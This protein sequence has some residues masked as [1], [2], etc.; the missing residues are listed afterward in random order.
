MLSTV[1]SPNLTDHLHQG[2]HTRWACNISCESFEIVLRAIDAFGSEYLK[3]RNSGFEFPPV[4]HSHGNVRLIRALEE[5][6]IFRGSLKARNYLELKIPCSQMNVLS[7]VDG[8][9]FNDT[10]K[11]HLE[12]NAA[13][14][15]WIAHISSFQLYL[16]LWYI[17]EFACRVRLADNEASVSN[18]FLISGVSAARE[19]AMNDAL[20]VIVAVF[21]GGSQ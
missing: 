5:L 10:Y 1:I 15:S 14:V 8:S 11:R 2:K 16:L 13:A 3:T 18:Q 21:H 6:A 20:S 9:V 19:T 17:G 4:Q 7:E 12:E